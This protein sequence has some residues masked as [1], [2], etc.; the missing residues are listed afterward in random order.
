MSQSNFS[1]FVN[2]CRNIVWL[3][4]YARKQEDGSI[5]LYQSANEAAAFPIHVP[6]KLRLPSANIV[7]EVKCHAFG[8]RNTETQRSELRLEAIQ[9]KR[10]GI[11]AAPRQRTFLNALRDRVSAAANPFAARDEVINEIHNHLQ[12]GRDVVAAILSDADKRSGRDGFQN[13]AVLSGFVGHKAYIPPSDDGSGDLGHVAFTLVQHEDVNRAIPIRVR[14]ADSRFGK[15]LGPLRPTAVIA[16]VSVTAERGENDAIVARHLY[17][18]AS[19]A[20]VGMAMLNDFASKSWPE[21]WRKALEVYYNARREQVAQD[22]ARSAKMQKMAKPAAV[23]P[24]DAAAP[25]GEGGGAR[26]MAF[27]GT[28]VEHW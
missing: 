28:N 19:R 22:Q 4:G 2:E 20:D 14:G 10:A 26:E 18:D 1:N 25:A 15:E 17:L 23:A 6:A 27:D 13:R 5:L 11:T 12:I 24:S 8:R 9:I 7:V 16:R 3:S 21:W